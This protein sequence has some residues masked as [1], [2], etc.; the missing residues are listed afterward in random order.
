MF[1]PSEFEWD[2]AKARSNLEKHGIAFNEAVIVFEDRTRHVLDVTRER[3]NEMR[4]KTVGVFRGQLFTVVFTARG[5][6][7]RI[8]SARRSNSKEAREHGNRAL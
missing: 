4:L 3:D 8:I 5:T 6:V 2:L 7:C 1:E